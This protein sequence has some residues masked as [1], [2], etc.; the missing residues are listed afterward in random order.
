MVLQLSLLEEMIIGFTIQ[1]KKKKMEKSRERSNQYYQNNKE[2][3]QKMNQDQHKE[4]FEEEKIKKESIQ[5][6]DTVACLMKT[7][8]N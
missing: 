4:L 8:K 2:R 7:D 1:L 3:L 5:E 6:I